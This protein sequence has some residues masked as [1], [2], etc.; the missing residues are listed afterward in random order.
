MA[1][2]PLS[3]TEG[4]DGVRSRFLLA[5][6]GA[7][8]GKSRLDTILVQRHM[9]RGVDEQVVRGP[10]TDP[11]EVVDERLH[12]RQ[13]ARAE[14]EP[15]AR[16][17]GRLILVAS[18]HANSIPAHGLEMEVNVQA[19]SRVDRLAN[20]HVQPEVGGEDELSSAAVR[21][22]D[23][24]AKWRDSLV[25]LHQGE[26]GRRDV[27]WSRRRLVACHNDDP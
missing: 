5:F 1:L 15:L 11:A 9:E 3:G 12:K 2:V 21:A 17:A 13:P 24:Y 16:E 14:V 7:V 25:I 4:G 8:E 10:L 23:E 18:N 6:H 22:R 27:I 20:E 26:V 19:A